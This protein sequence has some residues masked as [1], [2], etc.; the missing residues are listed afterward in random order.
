MLPFVWKSLI[1]IYWKFYYGTQWE[2][3]K[4]GNLFALENGKFLEGKWKIEWENLGFKKLKEL[5]KN[6]IIVE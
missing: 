3:I 5:K 4:A 1:W 6:Y 2:W